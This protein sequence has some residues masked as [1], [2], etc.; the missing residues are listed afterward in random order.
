[1]RKRERRRPRKSVALMRASVPKQAEDARVD[2]TLPTAAARTA[3]RKRVVDEKIEKKRNGGKA[4]RF[5]RRPGGGGLFDSTA[6][7]E[8]EKRVSTS[9]TFLY[10]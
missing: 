6:G 4:P 8:R 1:M 10:R 9:A 7:G 5:E 3:R 2:N